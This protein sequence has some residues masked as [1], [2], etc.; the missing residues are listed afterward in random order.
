MIVKENQRHMLELCKME[1]DKWYAVDP[2]WDDPIYANG[3]AIFA[4]LRGR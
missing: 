4:K 1:D 2:T 3:S